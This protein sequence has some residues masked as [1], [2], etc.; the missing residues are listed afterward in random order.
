MMEKIIIGILMVVIMIILQ[1][2]EIDRSKVNSWSIVW[3]LIGLIGCVPVAYYFLPDKTLALV[4]GVGWGAVCVFIAHN[5]KPDPSFEEEPGQDYLPEVVSEGGLPAN[6]PKDKESFDL[7]ITSGQGIKYTKTT[8]ETFE[9]T[10]ETTTETSAGSG[11][12]K[13]IVWCV[14]VWGLF[15]SGILN[16]IIKSL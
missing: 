8:K 3:S 7:S 13:F 12:G 6:I 1:R 5:M 15:E 4:T 11:F 2:G 9:V 10:P 16:E 14:V